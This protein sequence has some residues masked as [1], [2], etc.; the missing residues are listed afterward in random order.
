MKTTLALLFL[1]LP[2]AAAAV[3][4]SPY[5][6]QETRG[7]KA[8]SA[9]EQADLLAGKG[10][11]LAKAAELNGYPGPA[12]VLELAKELSLSAEQR[13]K[14]EALFQAMETRAKELGR[15]IVDAERGLDALFANKQV[16]A[17]LLDEHLARIGALQAQLRAAHL[18][19]HL[20]Q[21][22]ILTPGQVAHYQVLRGYAGAELAATSEPPRGGAHDHAHGHAHRH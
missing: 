16:T 12:H 21:V 11:G 18:A 13:A 1:T 10:M 20:E 22:R 17:A 15:Q 3:T 7:I 9:K 4:P 19:T 8:L 6:G 2:L 5:A 14:T